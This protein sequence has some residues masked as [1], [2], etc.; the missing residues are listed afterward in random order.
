L[1]AR[2]FSWWFFLERLSS[3]EARSNKVTERTV[4]SGQSKHTAWVGGIKNIIL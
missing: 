1:Q 3:G 4:Q 2:W